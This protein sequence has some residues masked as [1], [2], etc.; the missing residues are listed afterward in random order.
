MEPIIVGAGPVGLAAA[1]FLTRNGR[2]VRLVEKRHES[3]RESRALAVN[4]RTLELLEPTGVTATMLEKGLK[5]RGVHF[6]QDAHQIGTLTLE[7]VHPTYPFML[8]LSQAMTERL[9][10]AAFEATGGVIERGTEMVDCR[11]AGDTVDVTCKRDGERIESRHP[12]LLAADGAH[13]TVRER[14]GVGFPGAAFKHEWYLADLPLETALE[15]DFGHVHLLRGGAFVFLIRVVDEV[16]E[17]QAGAP[18]WRV[19]TNRPD[20]LTRIVHAKPAGSAV[21][22][23]S[24][25]V[26]HRLCDWLGRDR[27][28]LGGDAAHLHS[29][30]GAR[31]MNLG[32]ED[33]WVFAQ[34][35]RSGRLGEYG[36][37]RRPVDRQVVRRV[38]L[39]SKLAGAETPMFGMLR[40]VAFPLLIRLGFVRQVARRTATGLDHDLPTS[41]ALGH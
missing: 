26:S 15:H 31:G 18:L 33:A 2:G 10:G 32:I 16:L 36:R 11:V 1:V 19:I 13:S 3:S 6:W 14:M 27:I 7:G 34:L 5:I 38:E 24:F 22:E 39:I 8:A 37:L 40:R 41:R 12:W 20:P 4:P 9:L 29:P 30:I 28:Y 17:G 25:R 35:E 23:S 21:W